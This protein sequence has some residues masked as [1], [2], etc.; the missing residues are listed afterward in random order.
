MSQVTPIRL[1]A[2]AALLATSA[3]YTDEFNGNAA[4]GEELFM[5]NS[6]V[7]C[8]GVTKEDNSMVGPSLFGVV[9]RKAGTAPS[10]L[11]AS[12]NLKTYG[13]TWSAETL[14]EFL[15]DP[16]AKVPGTPMAGVLAD[17]EQR[18]DVIA[19]LYTLKE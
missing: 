3:A 6:C 12:E 16:S 2:L 15:A 10:L 1:F 13:V 4:N 8:H 14:N 11:G 19:Y 5:T 17:P 18:A 7:A 9:G